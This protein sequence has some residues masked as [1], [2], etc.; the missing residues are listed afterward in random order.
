MKA[1]ARYHGAATCSADGGGDRCLGVRADTQTT[2]K[3]G[4]IRAEASERKTSLTWWWSTRSSPTQ[5]EL[6]G[7]MPGLASKVASFKL[8]VFCPASRLEK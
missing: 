1:L 4:K 7:L 3:Q 8:S 2:E 5:R 6:G